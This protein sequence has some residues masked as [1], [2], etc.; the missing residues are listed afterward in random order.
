MDIDHIRLL[1][2]HKEK[3]IVDLQRILSQLQIDEGS[4]VEEDLHQVPKSST[5][6][7]IIATLK[8]PTQRE[9][10]E[11]TAIYYC[12][13]TRG[14]RRYFINKGIIL[15]KD[16]RFLHIKTQGG[17]IIRRTP[18]YTRTTAIIEK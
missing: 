7:E 12:K 5:E 15:K 11:G 14:K 9:Y 1:I 18:K 3:E 16:K 17:D 13:E 2:Q 4:E 6:A 10:K 8:T